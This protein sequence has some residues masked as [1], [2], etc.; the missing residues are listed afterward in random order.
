MKK[1]FIFFI[2]IIIGKSIFSMEQKNPLEKAQIQE[3]IF[4]NGGYYQKH[5]LNFLEP[6]I[7][8]ENILKILDNTIS[9]MGLSFKGVR[10]E[11]CYFSSNL[12]TKMADMFSW[13][14][15]FSYRESIEKK[16]DITDEVIYNYIIR[17]HYLE[18]FEIENNDN[19]TF[20]SLYY[21]LRY[22]PNLKAVCIRNCFN[23]SNNND[24]DKDIY[25]KFGD[26]FNFINIVKM[27]IKSLPEE[28]EMLSRD[29]LINDIKITSYIKYGD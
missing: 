19:I 8:E 24:F 25:D 23:F 26:K 4:F 20:R 9:Q 2:L 1:K 7:N 10:F 3:K 16:S 14:E 17:C 22:C 5:I 15:S 18:S 12:L 6:K 11:R 28:G 29:L 13:I 27:V 21:I